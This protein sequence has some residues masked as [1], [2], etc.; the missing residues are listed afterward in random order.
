MKA[1]LN[2]VHFKGEIISISYAIPWISWL[3][4]FFLCRWS[5]HSFPITKSVEAFNTC[6]IE[7]PVF[8]AQIIYSMWYRECIKSLVFNDNGLKNGCE[9][10]LSIYFTWYLIFVFFSI[11][12]RSWVRAGA[13][14]C[15]NSSGRPMDQK[16]IYLCICCQG[17][18]MLCARLQFSNSRR[19]V[20]I[21]LYKHGKT[22]YIGENNNFERAT[23]PAINQYFP[24]IRDI[25]DFRLN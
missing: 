8:I 20:N 16:S 12:C 19:T 14:Y 4:R 23:Q 13:R 22:P 25:R 9:I 10:H 17:T 1:Q 5:H 6:F 15:S 11:E 7:R 3:E 2:Q 24:E 18:L 21:H